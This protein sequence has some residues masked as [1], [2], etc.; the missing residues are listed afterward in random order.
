MFFC[1]LCLYTPVS[2]SVPETEDI[3]IYATE[4]GKGRGKGG[5]G[6]GVIHAEDVP[7]VEFMYHVFTCMPGES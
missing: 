5:G 1:V 6:G 7:L 3:I 2:P 4:R